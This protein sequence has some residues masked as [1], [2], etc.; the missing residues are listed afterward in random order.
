MKLNEPK[1]QEMVVNIVFHVS[2]KPQINP[3]SYVSSVAL[4]NC[5]DKSLH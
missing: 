1:C 3:M 4:Q 2:S 5:Y